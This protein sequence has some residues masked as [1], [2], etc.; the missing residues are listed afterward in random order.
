MRISDWSSVVCSSDLL[1]LQLHLTIPEY[2][3]HQQHRNQHHQ[4][5]EQQ[6]LVKGW[7]YLQGNA[8]QICDPG[9]IRSTPGQLQ[10]VITRFSFNNGNFAATINPVQADRTS[11]V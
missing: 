7:L 9:S 3:R 11:V 10:P 1:L 6:G 8:Q 4:N 2:Q 5:F